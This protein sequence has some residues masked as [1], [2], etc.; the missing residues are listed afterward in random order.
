MYGGRGMAGDGGA[1]FEDR[2]FLATKEANMRLKMSSSDG[3][4]MSPGDRGH[5]LEEEED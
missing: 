1:G 3:A 2:V 4:G 5:V